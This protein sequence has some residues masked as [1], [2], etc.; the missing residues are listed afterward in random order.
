MIILSKV[1]AKLALLVPVRMLRATLRVVQPNAWAEIACVPRAIAS[2]ELA[3]AV[4]VL[5]FLV[6]P[7]LSSLSATLAA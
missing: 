2:M 6:R 7:A 4:A 1:V 3:T 5:R